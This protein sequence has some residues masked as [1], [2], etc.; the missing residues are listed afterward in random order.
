M[1]AT[2]V[3]AVANV[4]VDVDEV[5]L[6]D[7]VVTVV[8]VVVVVIVVVVFVVVVV[9]VV[10]VAV[11]V[12]VV[13]A[14]VVVVDVAVVVVIVVV[15][16]A[17]VVC[18]GTA[19]KA[20]SRCSFLQSSSLLSHVSRALSASALVSNLTTTETTTRAPLPTSKVVVLAPT[21]AHASGVFS[22]SAS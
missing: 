18:G 12:V 4:N 20:L 3:D 5:V 1:L 9:V 22:Q 7:V 19:A 13:V 8:A 17:I 15:I 10:V 14:V 21:T 6:V 2:V 16:A 11:T